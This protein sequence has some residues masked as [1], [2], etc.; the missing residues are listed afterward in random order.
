MTKSRPETKADLYA[1]RVAKLKTHAARKKV[2]V[3]EV[4]DS[5]LT[6][7]L[8]VADDETH[9]REHAA[10]FFDVIQ[11][12]DLYADLDLPRLEVI[13]QATETTHIAIVGKTMR[14]EGEWE[15]RALAMHAAQ[16]DL[17][18]LHVP[19]NV[20]GECRPPARA[21]EQ[22]PTPDEGCEE[23]IDYEHTA[24]GIVPI[25]YV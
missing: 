6:G 2:D 18:A 23:K 10:G 22:E 17:P 11:V 3:A 9:W 25:T 7:G 12:G 15:A 20:E 8:A 4:P 16:A 14:D 19:E 1:A 5:I 21:S 24:F 13:G